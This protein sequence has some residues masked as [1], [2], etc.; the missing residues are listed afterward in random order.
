VRADEALAE[1]L[2]ETVA[3]LELLGELAAQAGNATGDGA[4]MANMFDPT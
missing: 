3:S 2:R 4:L 1:G